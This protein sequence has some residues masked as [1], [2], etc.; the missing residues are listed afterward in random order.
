MAA[1]WSN[2]S[3]SVPIV[4]YLNSVPKFLVSTTMDTVEWQN[5]TLIEGDVAEEITK[6]K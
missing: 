5:S 1:Y 3:A 4:D 6:L 2:Q